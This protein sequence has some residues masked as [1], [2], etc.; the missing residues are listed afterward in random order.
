MFFTI[1]TNSKNF[2]SVYMFNK[3]KINVKLNINHL[4]YFRVSLKNSN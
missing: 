3:N 4:Y 2:S 1:I